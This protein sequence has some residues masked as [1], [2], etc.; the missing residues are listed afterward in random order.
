MRFKATREPKKGFQWYPLNR[1]G[2]KSAKRKK[3][4]DEIESFLYLQ[5]K[6]KLLAIK[7]NATYLQ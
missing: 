2:N 3:D 4:I 1:L 7:F 6:C 5:R